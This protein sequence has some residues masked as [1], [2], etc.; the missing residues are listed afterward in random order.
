MEGKRRKGG[1]RPGTKGGR[2]LGACASAMMYS[3]GSVHSV[4]VTSIAEVSSCRCQ[5]FS[6][7][8]NRNNS[9]VRHSCI[10]G[11]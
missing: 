3:L 5:T 7:R 6:G 8:F 4:H 10:N 11:T 1:R 2:R 9:I